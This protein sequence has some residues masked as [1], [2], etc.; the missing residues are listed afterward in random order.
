MR[1]LHISSLAEH[2]RAA[3]AAGQ[4]V[5]LATVVES[6][7]QEV[8]PGTTWAVS[9][10]E[11]RCFLPGQAGG[12]AA[13]DGGAGTWKGA[14]APGGAMEAVEQSV[15][16][17]ASRILARARGRPPGRV[18]PARDRMSH[19]WWPQPGGH[20]AGAAVRL[21]VEL[22][23]PPPRLILVGAG[24]DAPPLSRIAAEAGF[25]VLVAD[26][27]PAFARPERFPEAREVRCVEPDGL[28]A[29][30]FAGDCYAVVMNHHFLRDA[31]ALRLL[32]ARA[33]PYIGVLGPRARTERLLARIQKDWG[34]SLAPEEWDRI[35]SP[36][37]VDLGGDTPGAIALSVVAE[38]MAF[39]WGRS[40]P[41]LR[42]RQGQLHPD[43]VEAA[44][45][46][47]ENQP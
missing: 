35:Y 10:R 9:Q 16:Q 44:V 6:R 15:L 46:L 17:H 47:R 20:D 21:F 12:A 30:W 26:P 37:G 4:R 38:I 29:E 40:V 11:A 34:R 45:P 5:C 8:P 7:L 1:A 18:A 13:P 22:L 19:L 33:V 27:R 14:R 28:P 23:E 3:L 31:A 43:R 2:V 32:L 25:E 36:V 41:H 42:D 39:R 24:Q